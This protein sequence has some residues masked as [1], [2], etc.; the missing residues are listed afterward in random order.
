MSNTSESGFQWSTNQ[1]VNYVINGEPWNST[2]FAEVYMAVD[3]LWSTW[4]EQ[5]PA[6]FDEVTDSARDAYY[7]GTNF[8]G[9]Y[10]TGMLRI[11]FL[12]E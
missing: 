11:G 8:L 10:S 2:E 9:T 6:N 3:D 12:F 5:S 1:P 7:N 4:D